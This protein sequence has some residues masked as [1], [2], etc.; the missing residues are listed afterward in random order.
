MRAM[1]VTGL[2]GV[3]F[4]LIWSSA[5]VAGK[6]AIAA[7]DP[8]SLLVL[9]FAAAGVLLF[10]FAALTRGGKTFSRRLAI[11]GLWLGA[12]NNAIY[13]GLSF[14]G[15][16]TVSPEATVLIVSTAPLMTTLISAL[17]GGGRSWRQIAGALIG[18][19]GV[20]VVVGARL[21]GGE[22][23][24]GVAL[25]VL[26][27]LAF[28]IGTVAYGRIGRQHDP[29]ALNAVQ[30]LSGAILLIPFA[31]LPAASLTALG[32]PAVLLAFAHLAVVVSIAG[33]LLWLW[34]V[35]RIG[36]AHAASFHLINPLFGIALSAL[37]FG[38]PILLSDLVGAA[39]VIAALGIVILDSG[40]KD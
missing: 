9:R 19:A 17:A 39:V 14:K 15:L 28:S 7:I 35:R 12:L 21:R 27:T 32:Q 34:L 38:S 6:L 26:G 10:V 13:L 23:P 16:E 25:I 24:F 5:F 29:V 22:D 3:L 11:D 30:T 4:S 36:A 1:I 18:F 20:V 37:I 2:A 33:F 31:P 8:L 40:R